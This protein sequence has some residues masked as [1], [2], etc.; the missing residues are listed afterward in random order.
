LIYNTHLAR[1]PGSAVSWLEHDNVASL[2]VG[3]SA[4]QTAVAGHLMKNNG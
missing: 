4:L 2:V 3:W 1:A